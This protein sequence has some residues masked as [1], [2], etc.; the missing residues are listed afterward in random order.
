MSFKYFIWNE[1]HV[2]AK[3]GAKK[4]VELS[5]YQ[6]NWL[7]FNDDFNDDGAGSQPGALKRQDEWYAQSLLFDLLLF[8]V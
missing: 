7:K 4:S 8:P 1:I 2:N 6:V 5:I 3:M